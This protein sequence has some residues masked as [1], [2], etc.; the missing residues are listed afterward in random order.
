MLGALVMDGQPTLI[1]PA[2]RTA[3]IVNWI[4][5]PVIFAA[6]AWGLDYQRSFSIRSSS[7]AASS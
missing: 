2:G 7:S 6:I 1:E 3:L 4:T 5:A